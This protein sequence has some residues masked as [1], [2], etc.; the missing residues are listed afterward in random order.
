LQNRPVKNSTSAEPDPEG[1]S[2][3]AA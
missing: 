2:R 1:C 3:R